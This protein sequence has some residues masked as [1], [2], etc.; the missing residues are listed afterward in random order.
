[1][2][3]KRSVLN[4][5]I[6]FTSLSLTFAGSSFSQN[7]LS[8]D[9]LKALKYRYIGPEGNRVSAVIGI[10]GRPSIYYVGAAAG[11]IFKSLDGGVHWE[12][13]FDNQ[14]VSSIGALCAAPSDPNVV[15]AG[16]G[17]AHIRS[18]ISIGNGIY[19]S[20]DA[21]MSW[22]LMGLEKTGRI[23]RVII[24]PRDP[25]TVFVAALGHCYGPQQERGVFKTSD[26][27]K[28]WKRVLFVD[29]NT[30]CSSLAIDPNNPRIL[31]AGMWQV[32]LHTWVAE[33]GGPGSGIFVSRDSGTTW[34]RLTGRGLPNRPVGKIEV[35]IAP[36]NSNRVFA[37]VETGN[38]VPWHGKET[39]R[40]VLWRSDDGGNSWKLISY[41]RNLNGRAKYYTRMAVAP[42]NENLTYYLTDN[43]S[44]SIDG[45]LNERSTRGIE[46]PGQDH[47][48]IWIDP[49]DAE[50]IIVGHDLGLSISVNRG[51]TWCRI[52]LPIAQM[53]HVTVDNQVPYNVYGN[54]Q[55]G[56]STRGPSNSRLRTQRF[57]QG[58][59]SEIPRG[60]W[61]SVGGGE[62]GWAT[63]DP[64]DNNIIWSTA[65]GSGSGGGIVVRYDERT[66][67][68]RNVEVWPETIMGWP[69]A[70]LKFRFAWTFPLSISPHDH[71]KLYVGSQFVHQ[72][73]NGGQSWQV[74]SPDLSTND[75]SRQQISGGLTPHN[76]GAEYACVIFAIAE[77]PLEKGL[78]W[79]GT[80]DGLVHLTRDGGKTWTNVTANIL[81]LPPWGT[82]SNIEPSRYNAGT[83]FM[84][85]DFHQVNN[86]DPYI[87]RTTD[88][89]KTWKLITNGITPSVL[90]YAHCVRE[91]PV[92]QG[93]LYLGTENALYVT[94]DDGEKWLP[95]QSNLPHAPV[96]W[97]TVQEHF[98]DLVVGTHGRG[99]WI[100]DD[101]TPLQQLESNVLNSDAYLFAPRPAFRFRDITDPFDQNEDPTAGKNPTYG[102]SINYYLKAAP[103]GD[104]SIQILDAKGQIIRYLQGSGLPGIN[105]IWWDLRYEE[106]NDFI[107]LRT[108]PA[109]APEIR[110]GPEGFRS[111][112]VSEGGRILIMAPPG[113][114]IVKLTVDNREFTQSLTVRKDPYSGGTEEDIQSQ[115]VMLK[116]LEKD[117]GVVA[118]MV[119]TIELVR[120]QLYNLSTLVLDEEKEAQVRAS[121]DELDKKLIDIEEN[122][123]QRKHGGQGADYVG[124]P[125]QLVRKIMYLADGLGSS[126]FMPTTQQREVHAL[127]K[128]KIQSCQGQ[129]DT[130]LSQDFNAF[131]N[132]LKEKKIQNIIIRV[133]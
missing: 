101:I 129:L 110:I 80:N 64:V 28:T 88:Y 111:Y 107:Q 131:N 118:R 130:L 9:L 62:S 106:S 1:M 102:A 84:T 98:N 78:I 128:E 103:R 100:L 16:T 49:K 73:T 119:N 58:K 113:T 44:V 43:F 18:N 39:D 97:L 33:S 76:I 30:G 6:V 91:D 14:Q 61:H 42:D 52:E 60:M 37:L 11:G 19:K 36:S 83:A 54:R 46:V 92:R 87:Y 59:W 93:L 125:A 126:D 2:R 122:L 109:Y 55:D 104:V 82:I 35:A 34:T 68:A 63:P 7:K 10:P 133:P 17:E 94:F 57:P 117:L 50:R 70:D 90:S 71:N 8:P 81:N 116:D 47:H 40:G 22:T 127:L 27:G 99:F 95:L 120:A 25:D 24:D 124:W 105:R 72:T 66:R 32:E 12:P 56:P 132:L 69:P 23:S 65:S 86:R 21:G 121:A 20:T 51:R 31:F 77:S 45:G 3:L 13:I 112:P 75:K 115:L 85:V 41:D 89:G 5:A 96:Y 4:A 67:Q 108:S 15:W 114:Y 26:G 29:E 74:I 123:I 53:Y 79:A 38:G 48:D